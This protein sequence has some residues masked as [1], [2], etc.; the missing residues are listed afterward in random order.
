MHHRIKEQ[1]GLEGILNADQF[2][3]LCYGQG[4]NPLDQVIQD[5]IQPGLGIPSE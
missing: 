2:Q 3:P 4:C 1:L 5:P